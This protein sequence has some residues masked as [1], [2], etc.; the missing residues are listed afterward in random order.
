[1]VLSVLDDRDAT[2]PAEHH[3]ACVPR[4]RGPHRPRRMDRGLPRP[5]RDR[6]AAQRARVFEH[7]P[8]PALHDDVRGRLLD[9]RCRIRE[10]SPDP[11]G[12]RS[13]E[14]IHRRVAVPGGR[15]VAFVCVQRPPR[16]SV[17]GGL[18]CILLRG[19]DRGRFCDPVHEVPTR[20]PVAGHHGVS[21][22]R[23]HR[24]PDDGDMA[25]RV[26]GR[27][28]TSRDRLET[29]RTRHGP[30]PRVAPSIGPGVSAATRASRFAVGPMRRYISAATSFA[31]SRYSCSF[32][33]AGFAEI[34]RYESFSVIFSFTFCRN[35]MIDANPFWEIMYSR[36][37]RTTAAFPP[38][39][40]KS[41]MAVAMSTRALGSATAIPFAVP[42]ADLESH[43]NPAPSIGYRDRRSS[44]WM[45]VMQ[46]PRAFV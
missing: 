40:A 13:G 1:M 28:G 29:G 6:I 26:R 37:S 16:R 44:G 24:H 20:I 7:V 46:S 10:L 43:M 19:S 17:L 3:G 22:P 42:A 41:E 31:R 21:D 25:H 30:R 36:P 12:R 45:R 14:A 9:D 32:I 2:N 38:S 27:G 4:L 39:E 23:L 15:L 34:R 11:P 18:L 5:L 35:R 8:P 33:A